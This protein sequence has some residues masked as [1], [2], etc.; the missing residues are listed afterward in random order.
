MH[1]E[2]G[3]GICSEDPTDV[4]GFQ[5]AGRESAEG[6]LVSLPA[7]QPRIRGRAIRA[8]PRTSS[9]ASTTRTAFSAHS[10]PSGTT[11]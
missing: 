6:D 4:G 11:D 9:G 3:G 8:A 5:R 2:T 10:N 1:E 7:W